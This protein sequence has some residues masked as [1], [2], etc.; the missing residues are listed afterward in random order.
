M[1]FRKNW[2]RFWTL[3]RHHAEG[4][5]LVELIVVIA[6][7]A[8]LAGVGTV[9]YSGYV[10]K[11]N[12]Q[13]DITLASEIKQALVLAYYS[14]ELTKDGYVIIGYNAEADFG[15]NEEIDKAMKAA[16]GE[17]WQTSLKL[18]FSGW[19]NT[20]SMN[21]AAV[22]GSNFDVQGVDSLLSRVANLTIAVEGYFG[23]NLDSALAA[24]MKEYAAELGINDEAILNNNAALAN[25]VPM[26]VAQRINEAQCSN[27]N[28]AEGYVATYQNIENFEDA[29]TAAAALKNNAGLDDTSALAVVFARTEGAV[30]YISSTIT[31]SDEKAALDNKWAK[32]NAAIKD[33]A[34]ALQAINNMN[35]YLLEEYSDDV[36]QYLDSSAGKDAN[37]F[38]AYMDGVENSIPGLVE[39]TS[40]L[41]SSNYYGSNLVTNLVKNYITAGQAL[42]DYPA[43]SAMVFVYSEGAVTC[44]P[45][46]YTE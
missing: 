27:E 41:S 12:M 11:A 15:G 6:I 45:L 36:E 3:D 28:F 2:K 37:A 22:A 42:S 38:L 30:R 44:S 16:F 19:E 10:K 9:G 21:L 31:D 4:F 18:A 13:A 5:T 7:L 29:N 26:A 23:E 39:D 35:G 43:E 33:K 40:T 32:Y 25:L 8:I 1:K 34:T 46:D 14:K 17:N 20:A 24:S